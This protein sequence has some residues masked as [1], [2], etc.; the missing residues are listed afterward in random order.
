MESAR[1]VGHSRRQLATISAI[2]TQPAT[3]K[4]RS[5]VAGGLAPMA[6]SWWRFI[7][8]ARAVRPA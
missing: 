7:A 6:A 1:P 8:S 3:R 2:N 5:R 4:A